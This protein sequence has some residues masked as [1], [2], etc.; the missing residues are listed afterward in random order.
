MRYFI[1]TNRHNYINLLQECYP[2]VLGGILETTELLKNR[3]DYIFFV[4]TFSF[5]R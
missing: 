2:V 3:F 4:G 1:T 5:R